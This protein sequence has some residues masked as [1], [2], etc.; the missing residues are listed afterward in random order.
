MVCHCHVIRRLS[1]RLCDLESTGLPPFREFRRLHRCLVIYW[2]L[3]TF[4]VYLRSNCWDIDL[5]WR[6]S[7]GRFWLQTWTTQC[8]Y[9]DANPQAEKNPF[10]SEFKAS[11]ETFLLIQFSSESNF[12]QK[13][14]RINFSTTNSTQPQLLSPYHRRTT[15]WSNRRDAYQRPRFS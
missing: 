6:R 7:K 2:T 9:S 5:L 1:F 11:R 4:F 3:S 10:E 15:R 13:F 8:E 14:L 12:S